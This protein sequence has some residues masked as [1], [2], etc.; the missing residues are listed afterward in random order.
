M[1]YAQLVALY[2]DIASTTKRLEKTAKIA[3]FLGETS[4]KDLAAVILLMQGRI[5]PIWDKRKLGVADRLVIK[6]LSITTGVKAERIEDEWRRLGN[7]G[8]V[9]E[10]LIAKRKQVTLAKRDLMV[11]DIM[12]T[13]EKIAGL[14]GSGTV[15]HKTKLICELLSNADGEEARYLVR[16]LLEDLRVGVATGVLRDAIVW[17]YL[18]P[19]AVVDGKPDIT[20]REHYNLVIAAVDDAYHVYN[21]F[22]KVAAAA[23][24]GLR[25]IQDVSLIVG[26]PVQ[27]ML[28]QKETSIA[29]AFARVG[30]PAALEYKYDGFRM[31]CHCTKGTITLFTRRLEDVTAQFPD[32]VEYLFKHV[33]ADSYIIDAEAVGYDAKT[34]KYRPFQDISQRIRRKYDISGTARSLPVELNVFDILYLNGKSQL[35]VPLEKRRAALAKIVKPLTG[36]VVL[37]KH[38]VTDSPKKA[39]AFFEESVKQGNEGLMFKNLQGPYRPGSRVGT[40]VKLKSVMDTLDLVIVGAEWGEGKRSGWLTSFTL[41]C[42]DADDYLEIGKVGTGVKE[43]EQEGGVTF[44]ELTDMLKPLIADQKGR[45]VTV[46][47]KVVLEIKFEEIQKSPTYPSGYALRFPRVI[48]V[49]YDRAA[50]DVATLEEVEDAF[51]KQKKA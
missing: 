35:A 49:R 12:R 50:E 24:E 38:I 1:K 4:E 42:A 13:L 29:D 47:P 15:D 28:A 44:G 3:A 17:A 14:S 43:L 23:R 27:A 7:L 33:K 18:H 2:T 48:Q 45:D 5:F 39:Q 46:R 30:T 26:H 6:A 16:T 9:A 36:K 34:N 21:D 51:F 10:K 37:A 25:A 8:D 11:S 19:V 20:D 41:A 40:M 32:V 22:S 31:Q